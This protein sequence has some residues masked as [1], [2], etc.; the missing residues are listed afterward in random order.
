MKYISED[1][2]E[3]IKSLIDTWDSN[4]EDCYE[5]AAELLFDINKDIRNK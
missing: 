4:N 1:I 5:A 3:R 2:Y